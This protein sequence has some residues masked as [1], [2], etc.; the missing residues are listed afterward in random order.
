MDKLEDW[1]EYTL[2]NLKNNIEKNIPYSNFDFST[3]L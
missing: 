3:L 1:Q 2:A